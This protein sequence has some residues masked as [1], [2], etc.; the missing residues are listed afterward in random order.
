MHDAPV[1]LCVVN[2]L[3]KTPVVA[4]TEFVPVVYAKPAFES[5]VDIEAFVIIEEI[6]G[7]EQAD[8]DSGTCV[9]EKFKTVAKR[10][11]CSEVEREAQIRNAVTVLCTEVKEKSGFEIKHV[12]HLE[13]SEDS[14]VE[15][16]KIPR[17]TFGRIGRLL[18]AGGYGNLAESLGPEQHGGCQNEEFKSFFHN[19]LFLK[20]FALFAEAK[21][22]KIYKSTEKMNPR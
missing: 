17:K 22:I 13:L 3:E 2:L 21:L 8:G 19:L 5:Q 15:T 7:T 9:G 10:E 18:I 4:D 14:C 6:I 1:D 20:K 11:S 16:V 12:G